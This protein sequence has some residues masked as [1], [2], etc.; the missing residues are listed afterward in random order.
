[1]TAIKLMSSHRAI[2]TCVHCAQHSQHHWNNQCPTVPCG[3]PSAA[4]HCVRQL[5]SLFPGDVAIS[6]TADINKKTQVFVLLFLKQM[7]GR[8]ALINLFSSRDGCI[9]HHSDVVH[10]HKT[11]R[12]MPVPSA[13]HWNSKMITN[14]QVDIGSHLIVLISVVHRCQGTAQA[15]SETDTLMQNVI[16]MSS[17]PSQ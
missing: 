7:S 4:S 6:R 13:L 15:A 1:M 3:L 5:F 14:V 11:I 10:L 16:I 17:S 12:V 9:P 8:L 2:N